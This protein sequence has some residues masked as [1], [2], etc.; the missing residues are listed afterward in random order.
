MRLPVIFCFALLLAL[1]S[2]SSAQKATVGRVAA[3]EMAGSFIYGGGPDG[4]RYSSLKQINRENVAELQV[5]WTYDTADGPGD[6][7]TQPVI[8]GGVLYGI[9]PR[10]KIIAL[11]A[12]TG[13]L[14]WRFDLGP[15]AQGANRGVTYWEAGSDRRIFAAIKNYLYALDAA[16]GKPVADFGQGGRIDLREGLGRD[17]Q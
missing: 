1:H 2:L 14:I 9:T 17:P 10:H 15:I 3:N 6:P 5:A 8:V 11:D 7:Q 12:A 4:I 13:R 16:T